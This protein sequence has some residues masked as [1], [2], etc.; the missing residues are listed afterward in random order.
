[1]GEHIKEEFSPTSASSLMLE[2]HPL[3]HNNSSDDEMLIC[4]KPPG[5]AGLAPK[6]QHALTKDGIVL[7]SKNSEQRRA[8]VPTDSISPKQAK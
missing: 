6:K 2:L 4:Y 8:Y 7:L 1:M 5:F 3:T